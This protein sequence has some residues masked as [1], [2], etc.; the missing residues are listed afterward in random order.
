[1]SQQSSSAPR[2]RHLMDPN[3]PRK[4]AD[5]QDLERLHRVQRRVIS[6]LIMTT[7][8]HLTVGLILAADLVD[9]D[10]LDAQLGLIILGALFF[11]MGIASVRAINKKPLATWWILTALIPTALGVW[12]VVLR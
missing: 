2:R 5:P 4:V 12:W 8:I 7:L 9:D 3:A 6:V 11:V 10:R 1:M